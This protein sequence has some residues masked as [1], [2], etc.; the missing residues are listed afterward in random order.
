MIKG[1]SRKISKGEGATKKRPKNSTNKP[2]PEGGN[3]TKGRKIA[4]KT[5]K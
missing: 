5:E 3:G 2:L 1:V 4:K